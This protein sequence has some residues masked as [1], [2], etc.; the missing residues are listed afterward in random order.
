MFAKVHRALGFAGSDKTKISF[1]QV[2]ETVQ[3]AW[4]LAYYRV[5]LGS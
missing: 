5:S 4:F 3:A 2:L 1:P